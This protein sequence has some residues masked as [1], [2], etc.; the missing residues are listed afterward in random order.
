MANSNYFCDLKVSRKFPYIVAPPDQITYATINQ[1]YKLFKEDQFYGTTAHECPNVYLTKIVKYF[2]NFTKLPNIKYNCII[3][4]FQ[5]S[6]TLQD[7]MTNKY[8]L[9]INSGRLVISE[10]LISNE[11]HQSF[12]FIVPLNYLGRFSKLMIG[13]FFD[14]DKFVEECTINTEKYSI[15][16]FYLDD[17]NNIVDLETDK[18]M[19]SAYLNLT[20]N[21]FLIIGVYDYNINQ[22]EFIN[23]FDL[24][25][26]VKKLAKFNIDSFTYPNYFPSFEEFM[27]EYTD[28]FETLP[29][30]L[31]DGIS[32][33]KTILKNSY[34]S[35]LFSIVN[36]R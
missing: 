8:N 16:Y 1:Q 17:S 18:P 7:V 29:L 12:E 33:N 14:S 5:T 21:N 4:G 23:K 36:K 20:P 2:L 31:I 15:L 6:L 26:N 13:V 27:N 9:E 19:Q 22:K 34:N 24:Y 35:D 11:N 3:H 32:L 30:Y 28:I 10:H 25:E